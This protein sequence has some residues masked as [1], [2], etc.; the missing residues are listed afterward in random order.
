[1]VNCNLLNVNLTY[2]HEKYK[3]ISKNPIKRVQLK[4]SIMREKMLKIVFLG[5]QLKQKQE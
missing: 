5:N 3:R 1:M 4:L 2:L